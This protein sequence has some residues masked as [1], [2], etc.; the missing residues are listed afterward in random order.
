M[1]VSFVQIQS[2]IKTFHCDQ[3]ITG[4]LRLWKEGMFHLIHIPYISK[5]ACYHLRHHKINGDVYLDL[6]F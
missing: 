1:Q 4:C 3:S 2:Q 6:I 5:S